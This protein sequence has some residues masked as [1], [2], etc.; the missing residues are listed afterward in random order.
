MAFWWAGAALLPVPTASDASAPRR[1]VAAIAAREMLSMVAASWKE[2]A[3][4]A[5]A[6][7]S[8]ISRIAAQSEPPRKEGFYSGAVRGLQANHPLFDTDSLTDALT[9]RLRGLAQERAGT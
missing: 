4:T 2:Y 6:M 9:E 1:G 5:S 3:D 8:A 7:G